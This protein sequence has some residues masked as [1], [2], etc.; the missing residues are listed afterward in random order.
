VKVTAQVVVD[1]SMVRTA[2][3]LKVR[4][5]HAFDQDLLRTQTLRL[6]ITCHSNPW[7]SGVMQNQKDGAARFDAGALAASTSAAE[8]VG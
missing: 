2:S 4:R 3:I 5:F 6:P 8:R 1:G 7:L